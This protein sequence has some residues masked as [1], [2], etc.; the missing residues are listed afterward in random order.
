MR[1][2]RP[3]FSRNPENELGALGLAVGGFNHASVKFL[4][5]CSDPGKSKSLVHV[6]I[7]GGVAESKDGGDGGGG[8]ELSL[9]IAEPRPVIE[10]LNAESG[11]FW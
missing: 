4:D 3:G 10:N 9:S 1:R 2:V 6:A 11:D 8:E 5:D 7:L